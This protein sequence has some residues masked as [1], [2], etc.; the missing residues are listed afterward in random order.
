[1]REILFR[2]KRRDNGEWIIGHYLVA[3]S[4]P[5][6]LPER[7]FLNGIVEVDPSTVC[8]YTGLTDKN[9]TKIFEGDVVQVPFW[10]SAQSGLVMNGIVEFQKAAFSIAWEYQ[11]YGKDFAGYIHDVGVIGNIHD[12][13]E[14][15]K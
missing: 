9:G 10:R 14:L 4:I 3:D 2:G 5:Y 6:I 15:L 8:Q 12:N 7:C 1:M 11:D 13:P